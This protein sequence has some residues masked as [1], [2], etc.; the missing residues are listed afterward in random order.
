MICNLEVSESNIVS[1]TSKDAPVIWH[2][3][4]E[5]YTASGDV[6][7]LNEKI[8]IAPD[9]SGFNN[10]AHTHKDSYIETTYRPTYVNHQ[11]RSALYFDGQSNYLEIG[12]GLLQNMISKPGYTIEGWFY[13]INPSTFALV[14]NYNHF[15]LSFKAIVHQHNEVYNGWVPAMYQSLDFGIADTNTMLN[16]WI[17]LACTFDE[18]TQVIRLYSNS[19][20]LAEYS[21]IANG[22]S[23]I[24]NI[25]EENPVTHLMH[26]EFVDL[27]TGT[28]FAEGY[29]SQLRVWDK[30]LTQF[31]LNQVKDSKIK[32]PIPNLIGA[33][34]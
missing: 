7:K 15:I 14:S 20:L 31:E 24:L 1:K 22:S 3:P 19:V 5:V 29:I 30:A 6:A 10:H 25:H 28:Y 17:H 27:S 23:T 32:G 2:S 34:M 18:S 33:W 12:V 16:Q 13:I 26:R 9:L 11:G 8:V 4:I 21:T